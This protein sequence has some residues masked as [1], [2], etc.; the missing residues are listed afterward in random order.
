MNLSIIIVN[1]NTKEL[2]KNGAST[3]PSRD[4]YIYSLTTIKN[5]RGIINH[6]AW[7]RRINR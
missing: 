5:T 1:Y 3:M 7:L 4:N 2:E 6:Q